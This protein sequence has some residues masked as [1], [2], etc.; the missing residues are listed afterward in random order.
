MQQLGIV[1]E[2]IEFLGVASRSCGRTGG[3]FERYQSQVEGALDWLS[4]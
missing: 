2:K 4:H 3:L 1:A